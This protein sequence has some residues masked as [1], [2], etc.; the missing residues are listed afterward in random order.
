MGKRLINLGKEQLSLL[1]LGGVSLASL[2]LIVFFGQAAKRVL[3]H[4]QTSPSQKQQTALESEAF[5]LAL[6][7]PD[8]RYKL[9][10][11]LIASGQNATD[12]Y[13]ASYLLATDLLEQGKA[14]EALATLNTLDP[15]DSSSALTPYVLL[16]H[17]Q[18]QLLTGESPASWNQLLTDYDTHSAAAEARYELGKRD[19]AQWDA[20]LA[21]HP[22]HP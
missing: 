18:A 19:P 21:K 14:N 4:A 16:K 9:L 2:A 10:Q 13:L 17:G 6:Q 8:I 20:L 3:P 22:N 5:R 7:P 15:G 11:G 1:L 12:T